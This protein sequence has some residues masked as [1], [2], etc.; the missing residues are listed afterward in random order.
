M[1]KL[2]VYT[3]IGR[4]IGGGLGSVEDSASGL[5]VSRPTAPGIRLG[6]MLQKFPKNFFSE[7]F[8]CPH[9]LGESS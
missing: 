2:P 7:L 1:I 9:H 8:L 5:I 6:T 3:H 4:F